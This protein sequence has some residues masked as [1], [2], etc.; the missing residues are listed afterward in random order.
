L[1]FATKERHPT[2]QLIACGLGRANGVAV[3]GET[4]YVSDFGVAPGLWPGR[5]WR[6]DLPTREKKVVATLMA[7]NGLVFHERSLY[8]AQS[9]RTFFAG[10]VTR[11]PLDRRDQITGRGTSTSVRGCPDGLLIRAEP[12]AAGRPI[13]YLC[14]FRGRTIERREIARWRERGTFPTG[15]WLGCDGRLVPASLAPAPDG[16]S[17]LFT[18]SQDAAFLRVA[19][20]LPPRPHHHIYAVAPESFTASQP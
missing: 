9:F 3:R 4:L 10:A 18:D 5:L 12:S 1:A 14:R 17:I 11:F 8:V 15:P 16:R 20:L 7:P 6:I 19:K 13:L 2:A